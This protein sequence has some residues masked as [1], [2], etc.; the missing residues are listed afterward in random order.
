MMAI[1]TNVRQYFISVLICISLIISDVEH[2]F[3]CFLAICLW[4]N[5]YLDL[6]IF[7]LGFLFFWH[8]AAWAVCI[9]RR[10][11]RCQLFCLQIFSPILWVVFFILF[12]VFFAVQ[13]F[14]SF[15]RSHLF[16]FITVGGGSKKILCSLCQRVFCLCFPLRVL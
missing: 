12:V 9:F 1:L 4:R 6:P 10:L 5:V 13:K 15:I 11:I 3:L 7:W 2:L 14:L 16:I 8:W